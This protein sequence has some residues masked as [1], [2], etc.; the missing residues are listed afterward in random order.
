M[1]RA[2]PIV[3]AGNWKMNHGPKAARAFFEALA[4]ED[5]LG[6]AE[7]AGNGR[8]RAILYV[9][10]VSFAAASE[11][12]AAFSKRAEIA[13]AIGSQNV[14]W[15]DSGAFTAELSAPLLMEIGITHTL[16][17]HSERRQF[18]GETDASVRDRTAFALD[19]G[20][21]VTLCVGETR[22]ERESGRTEAVLL[23]QL[24]GALP[25]SDPNARE[26]A[27]K[28]L[29]EGRLRI[30]YEPVWAIGTGLTATPAQAQEA[31]A[32]IRRDLAARLGAQAAQNAVILY[33]GSVTPAN[34]AELLACPDV[35][36]GLVG[37]AS[38]KAPDY[39][40]LLRAGALAAR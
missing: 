15:K 25:Q 2:R 23:A 11:A 17:G 14:H 8:L 31:H 20:M 40:A 3:I 37:G 38:L 30:A 4:G 7:A 6:V 18:F 36:G 32:L 9:P 39:A 34:V 26:R 35:D 22:A 12:A 13:V 29:I 21:D 28:A 33:G 27:A 1:S 10:A 24:A 16:V 5:I 19:Q